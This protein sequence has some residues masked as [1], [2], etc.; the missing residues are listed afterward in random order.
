[1]TSA[2]IFDFDGTLVDSEQAI[3]Q[4]FQSI[5]KQLAPERM[6]YAKNILIGPP[7]RDTASEIL[8]PDHQDSLDEFVQLFIAMHDEQV[9]QHTQPYPDVIQVLKQLYNKNISMTVATN[10][11]L[12]PTQKLIDHF[13]WN[14]Y[15]SFIECSDSQNEMRNKDSMIQ[16]IINQNE[17]FHGSFFVG[18]TVN[19]GLSANLNQLRFI[20]ACYGYGRDQ[21]WSN[22]TTYQEIHQFIE[23]LKLI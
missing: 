21:D 19:D 2:F 20:K 17:L 6:E 1:M 7:L 13:G 5:T 12:A 11:R 18:D 4:C 10:K 3:Y 23:I 15:F 22:V 9:I 14:D 8:G 16:D